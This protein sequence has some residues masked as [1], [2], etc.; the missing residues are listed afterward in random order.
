LEDIKVRKKIFGMAI[1][2]LVVL[3]GRAW[4]ADTSEGADLTVHPEQILIGADYNGEHVAVAGRVPSDATALIRVTGQPEHYKLKQKGRALGFLWMNLGSVE[5][6]KVPNVFLLYLPKGPHETWQTERMR[7][8]GLDGLRKQAQIVAADENQDILFAEFLKLKQKAGLYGTEE[9]AVQFGADDGRTKYFKATLALPASLPQGS[10]NI[11]LIT[12][13]NGAL[14]ASAVQILAAR[15]VG[16]PAWISS[17]AFNHGTVYGIL[18]VLVA[19]I[20]GL[21]TG[22]VFK[23]GKGSH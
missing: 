2:C 21:F 8:L 7:A 11:E 16:I 15:E 1:L 13:R 14:G 20:A 3:A 9:N 5:I 17:L 22:I 6:S 12:L 18:S 23:G 10:F 19:V 4:G